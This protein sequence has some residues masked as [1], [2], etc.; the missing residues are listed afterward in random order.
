[1]NKWNKANLQNPAKRRQ[2]RTSLHN[3]LKILPNTIN[4]EE[5]W[6][7]IKVAITEAANETTHKK[8]E[9]QEMNGG[10]KNVGN[11]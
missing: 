4:V 6:E 5:E 11:L 7:S 3:K 8:I 10:M 1:M 9:P 2:C